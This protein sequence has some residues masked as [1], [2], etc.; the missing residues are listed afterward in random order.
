V[1]DEQHTAPVGDK[2]ADHLE[3]LVGL[4]AGDGGGR[5]VQQQHLGIE[6]ERLGDLD[7]LD[8]RRGERGDRPVGVEV[9]VEQVEAAPGLGAEA[10]PV[11][12]PSARRH[13]LQHD[14]LP[15]GERGDD[16]ALL[17]DDAD[18]DLAGRVRRGDGDLVPVEQEASAVGLLDAGEDLDE[19]ALA[20]AVLAQQRVHRAGAHP[21]RGLVQRPHSGERLDEVLRH[22]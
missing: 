17:V 1:A 22:Q 2:A 9:E 16:V 4:A 18:A 7:E 20:R 21:Q 3:E 10:A 6:V 8:L 11:D 19:R 13:R 15:D 5:L 12:D 14:V